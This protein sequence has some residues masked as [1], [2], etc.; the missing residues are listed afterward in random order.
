MWQSHDMHV[1]RHAHGNLTAWWVGRTAT[2]SP[3]GLETLKQ[4]RCEQHKVTQHLHQWTHPE[5]KYNRHSVQTTLRGDYE[6]GTIKLN[7]NYKTPEECWL[8]HHTSLHHTYQ[9]WYN[10]CDVTIQLHHLPKHLVSYPAYF[11]KNGCCR[12][13]DSLG[14]WLHIPGA[15]TCHSKNP[16]CPMKSSELWHC[17]IT[18]VQLWQKKHWR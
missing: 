8:W 18:T 1:T 5:C 17:T 10:T 2:A 16:E 9:R 4:S 12:S 11:L 15:V 3:V 7:C 6:D 14:N 13:E